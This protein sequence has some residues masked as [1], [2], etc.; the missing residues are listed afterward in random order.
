TPV[1]EPVK[2]PPAA[3]AEPQ[4]SV[5]KVA[6]A[7]SAPAPKT[8]ESVSVYFRTTPIGA[9][10]QVNDRSDWVC[11]SP[12]QLSGLPP[13]K[14]QVKATLD[15]YHPAQREVSLG[16]SAQAVLEIKLEDARITALITSDP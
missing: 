1:R 16:S 14:Y 3:K 4:R 8:V 6:P 13:G 12:C 2:P 11:E 15:G 5:A 7:K 10:I 9:R